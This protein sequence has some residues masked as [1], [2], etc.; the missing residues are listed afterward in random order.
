MDFYA[1]TQGPNKADWEPLFTSSF[2]TTDLGGAWHFS[3]STR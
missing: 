3:I 1:H 2:K